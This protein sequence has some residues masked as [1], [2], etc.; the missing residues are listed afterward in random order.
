MSPGLRLPADVPDAITLAPALL[1]MKSGGAH[2]SVVVHQIP[3]SS[4]LARV[5]RAIRGATAI[6]LP[7]NLIG[8]LF[9]PSLAVALVVIVMVSSWVWQILARPMG[10]AV[11]SVR[12]TIIDV[13]ALL[14]SSELA[15]GLALYIVPGSPSG[16]TSQRISSVTHNRDTLSVVSISGVSLH[17]GMGPGRGLSTQN[18]L[19]LLLIVIAAIRSARAGENL[20]PVC[21]TGDGVPFLAGDRGLLLENKRTLGLHRI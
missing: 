5:G 12:S 17:L 16:Q 1:L 10:S 13:L 11:N 7:R 9:E 19:A 6:P 18:G 14:M 2:A 4:R 15:I 21:A 20:R 8:H 3:T